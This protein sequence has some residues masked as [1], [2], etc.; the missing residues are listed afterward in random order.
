MP[1]PPAGLDDLPW[2]GRSTRITRQAPARA[3]TTGSHQAV[4]PTVP[5]IS[6]NAGAPGLPSS[7]TC[8][9]PSTSRTNRPSAP[10]PPDMCSAIA[11][12]PVIQLT[13]GLRKAGSG[14]GL[15]LGLSQTRCQGYTKAYTLSKLFLSGR[16]PSAPEAWQQRHCP[17]APAGRRAAQPMPAFRTRIR[18]TTG[19]TFSPTP[20]TGATATGNSSA[21]RFIRRPVRQEA[22]RSPDPS[23]VPAGNI[24]ERR[25]RHD[26]SGGRTCPVERRAAGQA[27]MRDSGTAQPRSR[28][29]RR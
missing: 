19:T 15:P 18:N 20:P 5:W 17:A 14:D 16:L 24:H 21:S 8:M 2:P 4:E 22:R 28:V 27:H 9:S 29:R 25:H 26:A 7:T 6:S 11:L 13:A 3:G 12:S 1:Y 23:R 10:G